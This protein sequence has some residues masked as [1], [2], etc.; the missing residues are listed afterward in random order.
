M[1]LHLVVGTTI[2]S[3]LLIMKKL[4]TECG[5][6]LNLKASRGQLQWKRKN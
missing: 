6:F 3:G 4:V 1:F 2:Y 5:Q